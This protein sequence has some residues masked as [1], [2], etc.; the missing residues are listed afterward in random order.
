M[1]VSAFVCSCRS[2]AGPP[3]PPNIQD[4]EL[5]EEWQD[6]GFPRSEFTCDLTVR[7]KVTPHS[8]PEKGPLKTN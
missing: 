8:F 6:D 7:L 5:R 2:A 1:T 3:D 4:M